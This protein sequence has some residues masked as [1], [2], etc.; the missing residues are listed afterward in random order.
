EKTARVLDFGSSDQAKGDP[1][2]NLRLTL[3]S[4]EAQAV[5]PPVVA[6]SSSDSSFG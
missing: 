5:G 2:E 1:N 4:A 3:A 6:L